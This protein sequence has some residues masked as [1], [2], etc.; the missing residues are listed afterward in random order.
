MNW[1]S[2]KETRLSGRD[3][4]AD[5]FIVTGLALGSCTPG[6]YHAIPGRAE[7]LKDIKILDAVPGIGQS[8]F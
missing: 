2:P 3:G 8:L 5:D 1:N 7:E 6:V 4:E